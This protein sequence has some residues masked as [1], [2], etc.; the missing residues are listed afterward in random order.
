MNDTL[1]VT[2]SYVDRLDLPERKPRAASFESAEFA[3]SASPTQF[4]V[5]EQAVVIGSQ[6]AEFASGV[7][8]MTRNAIADS[9]LIA[10]LAANKA[11]DSDTD[12]MGWY[13]KYVDVLQNIGWVVGDMEFKKQVVS[14]TDAGVHTA[15]IPVITSMLVPGSAAL[16]MVLA[17]LNGLKEMHSDSKWMTVFDKSSQHAKG[18]KFQFSQVD[19]D[20]NGNPQISV[21]CFG[22]LADHTVTQVLF[23]KFSQDKVTLESA[24]STLSMTAQQLE[25]VHGSIAT[26]VRPFVVD[27]VKNIEI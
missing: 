8:A 5:N 16:T 12:V 15:I 20:S 25:A 27:Y 6:I 1:E 19:A 2:R 24:I 9:I 11:A 14:D 23:F 22:M 10:Q 13:R 4:S 17:V 21:L 3:E 18:A 7:D 26:R